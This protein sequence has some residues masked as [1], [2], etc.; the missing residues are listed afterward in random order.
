M[1]ACVSLLAYLVNVN[2]SLNTWQLSGFN[3]NWKEIV[4]P[5]YVASSEPKGGCASRNT[6]FLTRNSIRQSSQFLI[7]GA[8]NSGS[9]SR[10]I[11]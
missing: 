2:G 4:H 7:E 1:P 9:S 5:E 11:K 6:S 3:F 8:G 10:C